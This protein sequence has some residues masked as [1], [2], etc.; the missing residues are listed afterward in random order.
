MAANTR[1]T[2]AERA[3]ILADLR[4]GLGVNATA[5]KHGRSAAAVSGIGAQ[6]GVDLDRSR[7]LKAA[8]ARRDYAQP[9]RLALLNEA[10]D[11][12]RAAIP[13]ID[14]GSANPRDL[15][16]GL[17]ILIDKRRLEDGEATSR[18]ETMTVEARREARAEVERAIDELAAQRARRAKPTA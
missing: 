9:E 11:A 1:I 12:L 17:G 16:I 5:R 15:L 14:W 7:T 13:R 8:Q 3:A 10:F 6:E 2:G 18:G 4:A